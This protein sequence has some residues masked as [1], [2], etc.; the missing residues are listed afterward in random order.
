MQISSVR[1]NLLRICAAVAVI[2]IVL[3]PFHAFLTVWLSSLIGHYTLLRLWKEYL[4][5]LIGLVSVWQILFNAKTRR[6]FWHSRLMWLIVA[7]AALDLVLGGIAFGMHHVSARALA[8]GL[9]D[10]LRFLVFFVICWVLVYSGKRLDRHWVRLIIWPALIVIV[11][12]LL[13]MLVLPANFLSHFGYGPATI[14]PYQTINN[15]VHYIR[16]LS[17]L[18]GADPLGAY[19]LLPLSALGVMLVRRPRSWNWLK[20]LLIIAALA[21][22][23]GSYSRAA[24]VGAVL[25]ALLILAASIDPAL[26]RRFRKPLV[27]AVVVLLVAAG[28]IFIALKH[29]DKFQNI[30]FHTQTHSASAVSSD[31]A[32]LSALTQGVDQLIKYPF[33]LGAGTSGPASVYNHDHHPRITENYYLEIGEES[34]WLGMLLF[35]AITVGVACLLW[36]RRDSPLALTL[37]AAFVGIAFINLLTLAWTDDTLCYIWWGLAG[38]ALALPPRWPDNRSS[39][40]VTR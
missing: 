38:A 25:A 13:E 21:V 11:F 15:N 31:Q 27:V 14:L 32:H 24:W 39:E 33:G 29:S 36:Q 6:A 37:L 26:I 35:L 4:V 18:R 8:Y 30:I 19:L 7:Y 17:T 3:L 12:G 23:Y 10:D 1:Q 20:I 9:L 22:L 16:I 34:G 28:G 40:T 2:V 5:L